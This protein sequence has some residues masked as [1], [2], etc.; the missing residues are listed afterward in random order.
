M[1]VFQLSFCRM[2][3]AKAEALVVDEAMYL[4]SAIDL[5]VHQCQLSLTVSQAC[6]RFSGDYAIIQVCASSCAREC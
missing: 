3:V 2:A 5:K 6:A 4:W 1:Q